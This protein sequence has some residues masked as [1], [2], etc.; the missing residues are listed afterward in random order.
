MPHEII[1]YSEID[2]MAKNNYKILNNCENSIDIG[3][4]T[5][6]DF[7]SLKD[8]GVNLIFY[9]FP[10][11]D[12]SSLGKTAG[13]NENTRSGLVYYALDAIEI[14]QPEVAIMENVKNLVFK[15]GSDFK[16]LLEKLESFGYNNYYQVLNAKNF[17]IPQN[18]ERVFLV[19]IKKDSDKKV[20][21]NFKKNTVLFQEYFGNNQVDES[22]YLS[23]EYNNILSKKV[24]NDK[25]VK[26]NKDTKLPLIFDAYNDRIK[27]DQNSIGTL[28][29]NIGAFSLRN[30]TKLITEIDYD[31]QKVKGRVLT[32]QEAW[33][34]MGFKQEDINKIEGDK[35]SLYH[36]AMNSICVPVLQEILKKIYKGE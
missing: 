21:F 8:K 29:T 30:G 23:E 1:A 24:F 25:K 19:S 22:F 16:L 14:L 2:Q 35:T 20:D 10:C 17:G 31:N 12:I 9:G 6:F 4:I 18:R 13:I 15:F 5:K 3:D 27:V 11:Q 26:I 32:P 34:L 7:N 28:T 33:Q 36:Q